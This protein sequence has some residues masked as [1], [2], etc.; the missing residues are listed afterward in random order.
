MNQDGIVLVNSDGKVVENSIKS[1]LRAGILTASKTTTLID[2]NVIEDNLV[3]GVVIKD[4]SMPILRR[5]Q[6]QKNFY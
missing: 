5:N 1:N 2:A 4:P 3:S 6:I